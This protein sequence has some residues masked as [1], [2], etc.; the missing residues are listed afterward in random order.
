MNTNDTKPN[1]LTIKADQADPRTVALLDT[2]DSDTQRNLAVLAL[3]LLGCLANGTDK[4]LDYEL[5]EEME[6]SGLEAFYEE[7]E[8]RLRGLR[9]TS[10][11]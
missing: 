11:N 3:E 5:E 2:L 7:N 6:Q 9:R 4:I 8:R 1:K 10:P